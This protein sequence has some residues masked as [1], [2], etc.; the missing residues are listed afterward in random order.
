MTRFRIDDPGIDIEG[1]QARVE[2]A[3]AAKRNVRYT[4]RELEEI[5]SA[6]LS[7][8]LRREDLPRGLMREISSARRLL[9]EV[10][11]PPPTQPASVGDAGV[12]GREEPPPFDVKA[13]LAR[14]GAPGGAVG[15]VRRLFRALLSRFTGV[16]VEALAGIPGRVADTL[17]QLRDDLSDRARREDDRLVDL[18]QGSFDV[19]KDNLDGRIDRVQQWAGGQMSAAAG[20]LDERGERQL[21]LLHNLV[22][23]LTNARL[24]IRRRE[25]EILELTRR[26]RMLEERERALE[27]LTLPGPPEVP[28][29]RD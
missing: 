15:G 14:A 8:R 7:P 2:A 23:E 13:A 9:P 19:L 6:P 20:Q 29:S 1:L 3:I 26:I 22:F 25:D 10:P 17:E 27:Q 4:D 16:D 18:V 12:R 21:H 28:D 5:R 11:P 24:D